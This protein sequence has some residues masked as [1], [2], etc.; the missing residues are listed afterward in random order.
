VFGLR[1][2][3]AWLLHPQM[4]DK[5]TH[6]AINWGAKGGRDR[7]V[8][9]EHPAQ[10]QILDIAKRWA[11]DSTGSLIPDT[12]SLKAWRSHFYRVCRKCGI[13][14]TVGL[15]PHGLRHEEANAIYRSIAGVDAPVYGGDVASV[16]PDRDYLARQI[17][18]EHLGHSRPEITRA[19]LGPLVSTLKRSRSTRLA[20]SEHKPGTDSARG[21]VPSDSPEDPQSL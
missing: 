4:A 9:I 13:A 8:P 14:R 12:R 5:G 20:D 17:V 15:V 1:A 10:Q 6:L 21:V 16:D 2:K 19:Y 18:A 7:T 3:E 11:N